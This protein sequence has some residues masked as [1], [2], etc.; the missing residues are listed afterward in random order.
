M[1]QLF[2]GLI[3]EGSTDVRFLK[4]VVFKSVQDLCGDC[5]N[6]IEVFD[7]KEVKADGGTFVEKMLNATHI[8]SAELGLSMLCIHADS[9]NRTSDNVIKNKFEPFFN[10]LSKMNDE[11]YCKRIVPTIPIQMIESWMLADKE[12]LK[13]MVNANDMRDIDLGLEKSPE[14]YSDPKDIINNAIRMA[15]S[16]QSKKKRDQIKISDL[17]EVLGM[18]LSLEKLRMIPSFREFEQNVKNVFR[19]IGILI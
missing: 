7:I 18:R 2:V 15:M 1:R 8:A 10:E 11:E 14:T 5:E 3:T 17:Y 16:R 19:E 9:D 13:Q 12:L 4:N 6:D